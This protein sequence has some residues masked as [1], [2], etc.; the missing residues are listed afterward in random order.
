M[1]ENDYGDPEETGEHVEV[2]L[3]AHYQPG[4]STIQVW[5]DNGSLITLTV[6]GGEKSQIIDLASRALARMR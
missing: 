5:T 2:G 1:I 6:G 3:F 4:I